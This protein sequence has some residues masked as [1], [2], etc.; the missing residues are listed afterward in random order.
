M[1]EPEDI[2][3]VLPELAWTPVE[4]LAIQ[5]LMAAGLARIPAIQLYCRCKKDLDKAL[6]LV[7]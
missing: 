1:E 3:S 2:E 7:K 5:R 6:S 4:E